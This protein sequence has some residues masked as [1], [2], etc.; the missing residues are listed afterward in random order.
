MSRDAP[1]HAEVVVS[2]TMGLKSFRRCLD[3]LLLPPFNKHRTRA[4]GHHCT[5]FLTRP[6]SR[7]SYGNELSENLN[8]S[9]QVLILK[10]PDKGRTATIV[11]IVSS[12]SQA[13]VRV[14]GNQRREM[15]VLDLTDIARQLP[16]DPK[17]G[18][19]GAGGNGGGNLATKK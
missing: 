4:P 12:R 19:G 14:G 9:T 17:A 2:M 6:H 8:R 18:G 11:G 13:V 10:G 1:S 15:R 16:D 3:M 7:N 5:S